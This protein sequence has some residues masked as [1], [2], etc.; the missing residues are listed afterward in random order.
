M[1]G[2]G[3]AQPPVK[4]GW[5]QLAL[6]VR[7]RDDAT[8]ENFLGDRNSA[9][10]GRL[11]TLLESFSPGQ[12]IYLCGPSGSGKTHLLQALCHRAE[13]SGRAALCLNLGEMASHSA[14]ML[15]GLNGWDLV[16][17][18]DVDAVIGHLDWE[19]ALFHLFNRLH[20]SGAIV[21]FSAA[22]PPGIL[23]VGLPDLGSRLGA[24]LV[25]QLVLLRDQDRLAVLKAR[26]ERRGL[27][28]PHEVAQYILRRAPRHMA[29]LL[30]VLDR[31]DE[32]SLA[33]QRRLTVPFVRQVLETLVP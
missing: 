1:G 18:D 5:G 32:Q 33:S 8:F 11:R 25:L 30:D 13:A 24:C 29:E 26:A 3:V 23:P 28:M 14:G 12:G 20:D 10:A 7:L 31:L 9:V 17:L 6:G 22:V 21:I 27:F 4:S 2:A 19:E 15:E 16:C